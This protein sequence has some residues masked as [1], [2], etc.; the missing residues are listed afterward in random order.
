[1]VNRMKIKMYLEYL[2]DQKRYCRYKSLCP[3]NDKL[4]NIFICLEEMQEY[5]DVSFYKNSNN[6]EREIYSSDIIK[7][8]VEEV[9]NWR[10]RDTIYPD[11]YKAYVAYYD[12]KWSELFVVKMPISD[13]EALEYQWNAIS[14]NK[15]Q[16]ILFELEVIDGYDKVIISEVDG[17]PLEDIVQMERD[18]EENELWKKARWLC[19]KDRGIIDRT[20]TFYSMI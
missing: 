9:N 5:L 16:Y 6:N 10:N 2:R 19:E 15:P 3:R 7:E 13:W 11:A 1:M 8:C 18:Y 20:S 17:I 4:D 12:K 14:R